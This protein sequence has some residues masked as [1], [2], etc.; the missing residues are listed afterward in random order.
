MVLWPEYIWMSVTSSF[1]AFFGLAIAWRGAAASICC[2]SSAFSRSGQRI[3]PGGVS[4]IVAQMLQMSQT[5]KR[6]TGHKQAD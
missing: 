5:I 6:G 4:S 1:R 2:R 3:F